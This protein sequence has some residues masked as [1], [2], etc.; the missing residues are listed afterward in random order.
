MFREL[1][2]WVRDRRKAALHEAGHI[3]MANQCW[4]GA[5]GYIFLRLNPGPDERFW[6]G[7]V[8]VLDQKRFSRLSRLRRC[9]IAVAGAVAELDEE[10]L[11]FP[12]ELSEFWG[13][14]LQMSPRDWEM[15]ECHPGN[16]DRTCCR[17][18]EAVGRL[19]APGTPTRSALF[20]KARELIKVV[21]VV[22]Y[23][24]FRIPAEAPANLPSD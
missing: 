18:I 2:I 4:V 8:H 23:D 3:V 22:R 12:E 5:F 6:G 11:E 7:K 13:D 16:P 17:A 1:E 19:L 9:M 15:A 21:R 24:Q 10:E 20:F 14:P